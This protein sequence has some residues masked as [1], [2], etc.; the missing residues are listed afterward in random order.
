MAE[1]A[2]LFQAVQ[3][4]ALQPELL[5]VTGNDS[6]A[7]CNVLLVPS[8]ATDGKQSVSVLS[9]KKF[10]D[11]YATRPDS[12][13]GTAEVTT[14][15]SMV[16]LVNR[17]KDANSVLF[18]SDGRRIDDDGD[19]CHERAPTI[20]AVIDYHEV[21]EGTRELPRFCRH[22]V[23]YKFPLSDEWSAWTDQ[24]GK[25]MSQTDFARF[26]EDH[27]LDVV[28]PESA[29]ESAKL[30]AQAL[31]VNYAN[32]AK[33]LELSRGLEISVDHKIGQ[34]VNLQTGEAKV[35][36]TEEHKDVSGAPITIPGAFI[37]GIPV[38]RGSSDRYQI[39]TR[40]RYRKSNGALVWWFELYRADATFDFAF[41]DSCETVRAGTALPLY[42]GTPEV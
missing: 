4:A 13:T 40:L 41:R 42:Y 16:D 28:S 2:D 32:H 27:L 19:E 31:G 6:D 34:I 18:A 36:F 14:L 7:P 22:R 1:P 25:T 39:S 3:K 23:K 33:L 5:E 9:V 35:T 20:T 11:E 17:H 37:V 15:V 26:I 38:F 8:I 21:S 29:G 10:V 12:R 30:M 24:S